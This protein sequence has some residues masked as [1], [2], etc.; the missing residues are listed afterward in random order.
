MKCSWYIFNKN[1]L[2]K[3]C[4]YK[5]L[6]KYENICNN[7][8]TYAFQWIN[9]YIQLIQETSIHTYT[10]IHTHTYIPLYIHISRALHMSLFPLL[11][12]SS[13]QHTKKKH[14]STVDFSK[15]TVRN[16]LADFSW[17]EPFINL[18]FI[19]LYKIPSHPSTHPQN[20]KP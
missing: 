17:I 2:K 14:L 13:I 18:L 19:T 4:T 11:A 20:Q 1:K 16:I 9:N 6:F 7:N 3:L 15:W 10:Y 12:T 5:Y 8:Q